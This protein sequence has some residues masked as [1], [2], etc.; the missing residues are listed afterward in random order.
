MTDALVALGLTGLV[1]AL[2]WDAS[3]SEPKVKRVDQHTIV[4]TH[5]D[6]TAIYKEVK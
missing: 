4:V 3:T 5:G 2:I 1:I 6:K